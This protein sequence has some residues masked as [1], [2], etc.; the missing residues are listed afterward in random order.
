QEEAAEQRP[1]H[2]PG[3]PARAG[4]GERDLPETNERRQGTGRENRQGLR[5]PVR[6]SRQRVEGQQDRGEASR[7]QAQPARASERRERHEGEGQDAM[8]GEK[9]APERARGKEEQQQGRT[10]PGLEQEETHS[11]QR[12]RVDVSRE[13]DGGVLRAGARSGG[14]EDYV[15][16]EV[17]ADYQAV[18]RVRYLDD[19]GTAR[20]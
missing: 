5:C 17:H 19:P 9:P 12:H 4:R 16:D 13:S 1:P 7:R 6:E 2:R 8:K 15:G 20:Q 18:T 11:G 10:R 14:G 3:V